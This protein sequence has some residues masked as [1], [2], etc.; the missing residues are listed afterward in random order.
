MGYHGYIT[1]Y[2][3]I[4][5]YLQKTLLFIGNMF[6]Q[7]GGYPRSW[8]HQD[9]HGFSLVRCSEERRWLTGNTRRQPKR[10]AGKKPPTLPCQRRFATFP[11]DSKWI[12]I[13]LIW[14]KMVRAAWPWLFDSFTVLHY[15]TMK[16]LVFMDILEV[17]TYHQPPSTGI[18]VV[19]LCLYGRKCQWCWYAM[20][21]WLQLSQ[22]VNKSQRSNWIG[23]E[24][25]WPLC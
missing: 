17:V 20:Q 11:S 21:T 4:P 3:G 7:P 15:V 6:F 24:I 13:K 25:L 9:P 16:S 14:K 10:S 8:W 22:N 1:V 5:I 2:H 19:M 18:Q 23:I 12:W